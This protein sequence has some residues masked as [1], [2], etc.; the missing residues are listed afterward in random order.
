M[1]LRKHRKT[2]LPPCGRQSVFLAVHVLPAY[3][4][5]VRY[6]II[7][8]PPVSEHWKHDKI[9][10]HSRQTLRIR[11]LCYSALAKNHLLTRLR[12]GLFQL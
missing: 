10:L 9:E 11:R 8:P 4:A 1:F 2:P 5:S 6:W 12:S 7:K 3:V